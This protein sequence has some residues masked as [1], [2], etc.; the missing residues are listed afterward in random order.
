MAVAH[1]VTVLQG[2]TSCG[3]LC[4]GV[5]RGVRPGHDVRRVRPAR[6]AHK[7]YSD[8]PGDYAGSTGGETAGTLGER[9]EE[10]DG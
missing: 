3:R 4:T 7:A 1:T 10:E 6:G 5:V 9:D 2:R 8:I